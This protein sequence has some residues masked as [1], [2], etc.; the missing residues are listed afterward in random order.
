[1]QSL[2]NEENPIGIYSSILPPMLPVATPVEVIEF[3]ESINRMNLPTRLSDV[4][5]RFKKSTPNIIS[6]VVVLQELG[7]VKISKGCLTL[8][9]LGREFL[10]TSKARIRILRARLARLEPVRTARVLLSTRESISAQDVAKAMSYT[11]P[12]LGRFDLEVTSLRLRLVDWGVTM[13][14]F[15][16]NGRTGKFTLMKENPSS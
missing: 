9:D 1:M 8:T 11:Y 3:F 6:L 10:V 14:L 2:L 16:Y 13:T 15:S 4:D 5:R 7:L 12:G